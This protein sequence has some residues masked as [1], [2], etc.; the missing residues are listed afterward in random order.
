MDQ[1]GPVIIGSGGLAYNCSAAD[2]TSHLFFAY[3]RSLSPDS[4]RGTNGISAL[5]ISLQNLVQATEYP[6]VQPPMNATSKVVM[7]VDSVSPTP[8]ALLRRA[9][10]F[11]YRDDDQALQQFSDYV[12]PVQALTDEC[13]RVLKSISSINQ[14]TVSTSKASTSLPDASWSRFEDIGFGGFGEYSDNEDEIDG[15]A[16]GKKRKT[17]EGIRSAPRSKTHDHGRPTTPSWADFLSSGFADEASNP[18]PAPLLLPPEKQLPPITDSKRGHSSQ[19]HRRANDSDL[20]PGELASINAINIEDAFWWVWISSLAGEE[21][22]ARKGVFGRC[23]L[24]ET[25]I[26]GSTWLVI[27]EMVKGAAPEPEVGAY[28]AEK[29]SRFGFS[30][31][32]RL[33]RSV[34]KRGPPTPQMEPYP[35]GAQVSPLSKT[36]IGGDQHARIQ[37][38]AAALQQKQKQND[39]EYPTSP[40]RAGNR[41][42][43][44]TKTNSVFTLQPVIMNEAAPAMQWANKYD[45]NAIRAAYLGNNFTGKGSATDLGSNALNTA[46]NGSVSP[47]PKTV[48]RPVSYNFPKQDELPLEES[49]PTLNRDLPALPPETPKEQSVLTSPSQQA[50]QPPILPENKA[51]PLPSSAGIHPSDRD[52]NEASDVPLPEEPPL[53]KKSSR[54]FEANGMTPPSS[55]EGRKTNKLKKSNRAGLKGFFTKRSSSAAPQQPIASDAV[56]AARAAY[57]GPQMRPNYTSSQTTLGRRLSKMRKSPAA[58][59]VPP[60]MPPASEEQGEMQYSPEKEYEEPQPSLSRGDTNEQHDANREIDH[61]HQ[62]DNGFGK[63]EP[64]DRYD[65]GLKSDEHHDPEYRFDQGPMTEEPAFVPEDSPERFATPVPESEVSSLSED[66]QLSYPASKDRW[67]QIKKNAYERSAARQSEDQSRPSQARE[68]DD[69]ESDVAEEESRFRRFFVRTR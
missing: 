51:P 57:P 17:P 48:P 6:P 55:P 41:D 9:K 11:Q 61:I 29:K 4:V 69:G 49:K 7:F 59:V 22:T 42:A 39:A 56:A 64:E 31:R 30:K 14:S 3:L 8:F 67:A 2:A 65:H 36:S 66:A 37:A 35:R 62:D 33:Q 32:S 47:V 26:R 60:P 34:T 54:N 46:T 5:P 27:E 44:S 53:Q 1:V 23:A 15:S 20:E 38:A 50:I 18:G 45:K 25:S 52:V 68:T 16:F 10:H 43:M 21:P 63:Q 19:S 40:R 13:R 12:D 24:I 58:S 28:I